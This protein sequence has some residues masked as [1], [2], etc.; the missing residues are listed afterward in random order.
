ML[1]PGL[2]LEF[3]NAGKYI[4]R[5]LISHFRD[6][7]LHLQVAEVAIQRAGIAFDLLAE[8]W[9]RIFDLEIPNLE[10]FEVRFALFGIRFW[11]SYRLCNLEIPNLE[12][13][14]I[15][16]WVPYGLCTLEIPNLEHLEIRFALLEIRFQNWST[17]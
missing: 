3:V 6:V 9:D 16:F 10:H 8:G 13:L 17:L 7:K 4:C 14:E 2:T 1:E 5:E 15:R 12:H 11:A